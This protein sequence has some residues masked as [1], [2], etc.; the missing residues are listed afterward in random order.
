MQFRTHWSTKGT[1]S[2]EFV[3]SFKV[4]ALDW[5]VSTSYS[6]GVIEGT[7]PTDNNG[8]DT[9]CNLEH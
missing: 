7:N 2:P 6:K 8:I 9:I 1:Y 4:E 3:I 5:T